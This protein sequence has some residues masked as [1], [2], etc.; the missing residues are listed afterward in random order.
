MNMNFQRSVDS[1]SFASVIWKQ[2]PAVYVQFTVKKR[3]YTNGSDLRSY[4][5]AKGVAKKPNLR[6]WRN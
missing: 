5:A 3:T 4:E 6:Q 2:P 1:R